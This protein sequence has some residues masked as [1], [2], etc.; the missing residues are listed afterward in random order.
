MTRIV[1]SVER[2][3]QYRYGKPWL[4]LCDALFLR[5]RNGRE[6]QEGLLRAT[7]ILEVPPG[8]GERA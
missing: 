8:R 2:D 6:G 4:A 7:Q 3:I 1:S 5:R